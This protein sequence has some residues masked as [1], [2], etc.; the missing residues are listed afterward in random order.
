MVRILISVFG[1][2]PGR[3]IVIYDPFLF[4]IIWKFPFFRWSP[5]RDPKAFF[6]ILR[7]RKIKC[8]PER[9]EDWPQREKNHLV[10]SSCWSLTYSRNSSSLRESLTVK[11]WS[12]ICDF[13]PFFGTGREHCA[14][15]LEAGTVE[16]IVVENERER[17][18]CIREN[19]AKSH[20]VTVKILFLCSVTSHLSSFRRC[21]L[22]WIFTTNVYVHFGSILLGFR[23]FYFFISGLTPLLNLH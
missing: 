16:S 11:R 18:S 13:C 4:R 14:H 23:L 17:K 19:M 15:F 22:G 21:S 9:N 1:S 20:H 12:D 3:V 2:L 6:P 5:S 8:W 10:I 7:E